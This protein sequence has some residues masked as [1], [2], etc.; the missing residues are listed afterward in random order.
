V[1]V[2]VCVWERW[3]RGEAGERAAA[4]DGLALGCVQPETADGER[5][6]GASFVVVRLTLPPG[7][8]STSGQGGGREDDIIYF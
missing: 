8:G 3:E 2:C 5:A 4:A 6:A 7:G 1:C